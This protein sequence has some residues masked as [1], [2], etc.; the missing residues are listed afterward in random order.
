[1]LTGRCPPDFTAQWQCP[2]VQKCG[3][4]MVSHVRFDTSLVTVSYQASQPAQD[5]VAG[6][7]RRLFRWLRIRIPTASGPVT[8]YYTNVPP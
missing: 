4:L 2:L 1:M 7:A 6:L 5:P 8:A 3:D